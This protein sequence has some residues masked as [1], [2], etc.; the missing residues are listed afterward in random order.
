MS[1]RLK[2][3]NSN[4][5]LLI[6]ILI[7]SIF[8][9]TNTVNITPALGTNVIADDDPDDP[10][11]TNGPGMDPSSMIIY[12]GFIVHMEDNPQLDSFEGT[13]NR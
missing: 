4:K 7:G 10:G 2:M 6:L 3:K 8:V 1:R 12:N 11:N 13:L 5:A 9:I